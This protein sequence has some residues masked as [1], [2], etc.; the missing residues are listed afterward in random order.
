MTKTSIEWT[1]RPGTVGL[2]WNPIRA[3]R[4]DN[5][6]VGWACTHASTGCIH[7]YAETI[8]KR[9]GTKLP[10]NVQSLDQIEFFLDEKILEQPL[11]QKKPA[12]IFVGDMFDLFHEA[13]P[14][15]LIDR[16]FSVMAHCSEVWYR[17]SK[18]DCDHDPCDEN[19]LEPHQPHTFQVLTKRAE[20]MHAYLSGILLHERLIDAWGKLGWYF[21]FPPITKAL[22]PLPNVWCGVSVEN[23]KYADERIPLLLQT[24]AAIRFLSVEP[25]LEEIQFT[26]LHQLCPEH[27]FAG[28]FCTQWHEGM[29]FV[30]WVICGGESGSGARMFR[31]EW[32]ESL[33]EQCRAA[34]VA[35]FMKQFGS[36]AVL[37]PRYDQ[38]LPGASRKLADRKGGDPEEWPEH[39]RVREFPKSA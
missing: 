18:R 17:C 1:H 25:Q 36:Y 26:R 5:G 20:R 6:K 23:Q 29:R 32:A 33:L 34:N 22:I 21:E 7:C 28:G 39:L 35:F 19:H 27:D 3:R 31:R 14:D 13:I 12:T 24:P 15:H 38:T 37:D 2:T 4:K 11:R 8:N 10:F 16:V 9:F 30:D